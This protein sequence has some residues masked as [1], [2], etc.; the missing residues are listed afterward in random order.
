[1]RKILVEAGYTSNLNTNRVRKAEY[2]IP[3]KEFPE[4]LCAEVQ[5]VLRW[6]QDKYVPSRP[7]GGQIRA[8]TAKRIEGEFCRLYGYCVN[9]EKLGNISNLR[10]LVTEQNV[11]NFISWSLNN[12]NAK[13]LGLSIQLGG[14]SAALSQNPKF[15]DITSPWMPKLLESIPEDSG[16]ETQRRKEEKYLPYSVLCDIAPAIRRERE[17]IPEN[18]RKAIAL[19]VR[20]ELVILWLLTLPWRQRN[21]RECRVGGRNPN[22]LHGPLPRMASITKPDWL[23]EAEEQNGPLEVWQFRFSPSETKTGNGLAPIFETNG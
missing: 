21:I 14:L 16:E 9:I 13:G 10:E 5:E 19:N 18:H 2:G 8:I 6:K 3:L 12:R 17:R 23:L 15:S 20:D 1:M 7:K 11:G 22:L 4:M